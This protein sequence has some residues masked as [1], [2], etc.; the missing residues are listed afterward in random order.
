MPIP[1]EDHQPELQQDVELPS[2]PPTQ[3]LQPAR[4]SHWGLGSG[5]RQDT[6]AGTWAV[7]RGP[8][9]SPAAWPSSPANPSSL[10]KPTLDEVV[11]SPSKDFLRIRSSL[12]VFHTHRRPHF[13]PSSLTCLLSVSPPSSQTLLTQ[14]FP[15]L[16]LHFFH[17]DPGCSS[18]ITAGVKHSYPAAPTIR[19]TSSGAFP[20]LASGLDL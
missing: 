14:L 4:A 10:Y 6:I 11:S 17:L 7:T 2:L 8:E 19:D 13:W 20:D 12:S 1:R 16:G 9:L 5:G 3:P 15:P 18:R